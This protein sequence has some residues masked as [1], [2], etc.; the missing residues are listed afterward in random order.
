[1]TSNSDPGCIDLNATAATKIEQNAGHP[2]NVNV[3]ETDVKFE[4]RESD[5]EDFNVTPPVIAELFPPHEREG[6]ANIDQT[7]QNGE[8]FMLPASMNNQCVDE[9]EHD[10]RVEA[11]IKEGK[12]EKCD[13][14]PEEDPVKG[15]TIDNIIS[16]EEKEADIFEDAQENVME[17]E[18]KFFDDP[19][20]EGNAAPRFEGKSPS[21][22]SVGHFDH[23]PAEGEYVSNWE[24]EVGED[25]ESALQKKS[26]VVNSEPN[27]NQMPPLGS[28]AHLVKLL[29]ALEASTASEMKV[30]G[31]FTARVAVDQRPSSN[32]ISSL[33][34]TYETT[35]EAPHPPTTQTVSRMHTAPTE[36]SSV[37]SPKDAM[38]QVSTE[39]DQM[40]VATRYFNKLAEQEKARKAA[41]FAEWKAQQ[42]VPYATKYFNHIE[43]EK[44]AKKAAL[45]AQRVDEIPVATLHFQKIEEEK[46][47]RRAEL[48][49]QRVDEVPAATLHF[50]RI[51]EEKKRRQAELD[52]ARPTVEIPVATQYFNKLAEEEKQRKAALEAA[53]PSDEIPIATK[54]FNAIAE[55]EKRRKAELEAARTVDEVPIATRYFNA[56]A[57][58]ERRLKAERDAVEAAAPIPVAM[59]H[60][61]KQK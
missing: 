27:G 5:N 2:A 19:L 43:N 34:V 52:A 26:A 58:E 45:E 6:S 49:A 53:R 12:V 13:E 60:F 57:E 10:D 48:E 61:S 25:A 51:E 36:I 44:K 23:P 3:S 38:S 18:G 40:A 9:K 21:G 54:H 4:T 42:P 55:A 32:S 50:Q 24:S 15:V 7:E 17:T 37:K 29:S 47:A 14:T 46:N 56:I 39:M 31:S 16:I 33:D 1:M 22:E 8:H 41:E 28:D 30:E 11:I 59:Q 35:T 20:V